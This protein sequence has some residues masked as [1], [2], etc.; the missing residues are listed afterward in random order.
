MNILIPMAGAGSRFSEAGY[1]THKPII[2]VSSR[3]RNAHVPMVVA[4]VEDLPVNVDADDTH[5]IFVA[6]DFHVR[7]GVCDVL[8]ERFPRAQFITVDALTE[9]QASTCLLARSLINN[10]KPLLIAACDNGMDIAREVFAK[11]AQA[12]EVIIFT[13]RHN[14]AVLAKPQAYGWIKA[15]DTRATGVSIKVPISQTP[16]EDHAVVGTFWF[17]RGSDFVAAADQMIAADDRINGEFYVDQVMDYLINA[18]RDVRVT[19]VARYHCWGTP[20]D[21]EAYENT[22]A[23]WSSF[24]QNEPWA[25]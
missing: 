19:E 13:F 14:E 24:I 7:D 1:K 20:S 3:H 18:G 8:R 10:D 11:A 21:Y 17:R 9:G 25:S 16:M 15:Q 2:P 6:R 12:S 4:A 22:L 5:L 23:Y